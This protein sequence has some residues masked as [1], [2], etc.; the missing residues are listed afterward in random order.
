ML[1]VITN[2][3]PLLFGKMGLFF[4][5]LPYYSINLAIEQVDDQYI[6]IVGIEKFSLSE[7]GIGIIVT[8]ENFH[9]Q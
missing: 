7:R 2:D 6:N 4:C 9:S 5:F 8:P 3:L 1:S